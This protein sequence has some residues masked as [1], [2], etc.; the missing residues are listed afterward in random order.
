MMKSLAFDRFPRHLLVSLGFLLATIGISILV[1]NAQSGCPSRD[2]LPFWTTCAKVYYTFGSNITDSQQRSQI[3]TAIIRWNTANM[4][5]GSTVMFE[6]GS[7]PPG[8]SNP[9]TL[10]FQNGSLPDGV[11]GQ[12][13]SDS[14]FGDGLISA[15]ITFNPSTLITGTNIR[16]Y[17]PNAAGYDTVYVKQA[18]HEMGHTMGLANINRSQQIALTS[19]MNDSIDVNDRSNNQPTSPQACDNTVIMSYYPAISCPTPTPT[20]ASCPDK[21]YLIDFNLEH[22]ENRPKCGPATDFCKYP[23]D[24]VSHTPGGCPK[25]GVYQYNWGDSCC[26]DRPETPVVI[27]IAGD[28]FRLT[29]FADGV[30]FDLNSN[31]IREQLSWTAAGSD[32]AFLVLDRNGNGEIDNGIEL[33]G[34]FTPQPDSDEPNGFLALA[35]FDK[36]ANG[37]NTDGVIDRR[38]AIFASLRLWQDANHNGISEP[39]ELHALQ[40]RGLASLDLKYKE[41]KRA[42]Q[43]GNQFRYR[44]KVRDVRGAQIGRWAWDVFLITGGG[45]PQ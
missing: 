18:L 44:A 8:T 6:Q 45:P 41:S 16:F 24:P 12:W 32:D 4:A 29:S 11:A 25:T 17:D 7:P 43:Y 40:A 26:C 34:N 9:R 2:T 10:T 27:D 36:A 20:P 39:D 13:R 3:Q 37:G 15:T 14:S 28:G 5:N 31:G 33:F 23:A 21:C 30:E 38:D 22:P 42:D 19:T 35:E 1:V